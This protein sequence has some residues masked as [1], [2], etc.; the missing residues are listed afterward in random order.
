MKPG[1][2]DICD[3]LSGAANNL[4]PRPFLRWAGSKRLLLKHLNPLIPESYGTYFEP[5]AGSASLYFHLQPKK[6]V[7]NDKAAEVIDLYGAI[8]EDVEA[9]LLYCAQFKNTKEAYYNVR[10][11]RSTNPT[12]RAA[13]FLFLNKTCWNGLFRVNTSG[14]FNVP[15]GDNKV[16]QLVDP[17]N[18]R[19][20]A[21]L[22]I[23]SDV[24]LLNVDFEEAVQEAD[25]GDLVYFDPP[26][27]T[28]H[29]N[30][31]FLHYNEKI[32]SWDDQIRLAK[33]AKTLISRG[34]HVLVSNADHNDVA[35]LYDGF[36]KTLIRRNS[37][38]SGNVD[39]RG[40]I[41]EVIFR[42]TPK[43]SNGTNTNKQ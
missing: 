23:N 33:L 8:K 3:I 20:C 17:A 1:V 32:F 14:E 12:K 34:V 11:N 4:P 38:I 2:N 13:E 24:A 15:Y 26:Y 25:E 19:S 41:S 29:N 37:T 31:G 28:G 27:V 40:P 5:F 10:A 16:I 22:M 21:Q 39:K 42:S 36:Y 9:I 18:L 35:A 7:L 30:N 6:A 43:K